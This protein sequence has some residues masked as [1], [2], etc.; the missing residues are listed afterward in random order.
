MPRIEEIIGRVRKLCLRGVELLWG[1]IKCSKVNYGA[2]VN[3]VLPLRTQLQIV[4]QGRALCRSI[5]Q[6]AGL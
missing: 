4:R 1:V 2:G 5:I 6:L 3:G